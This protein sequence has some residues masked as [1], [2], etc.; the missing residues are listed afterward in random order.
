MRKTLIWR[1]HSSQQ[2]PIS[3]F[4]KDREIDTHKRVKLDPRE[5]RGSNN[6]EAMQVVIEVVVSEVEGVDLGE[7]FVLSSPTQVS[8]SSV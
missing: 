1:A 5:M 8:G 7:T 2:T 3:V 4:W 6:K